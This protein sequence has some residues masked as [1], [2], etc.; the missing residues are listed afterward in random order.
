MSILKK[1]VATPLAGVLLFTAF[2]MNGSAV[3]APNSSKNQI[4]APGLVLE[5]EHRNG[6]KAYRGGRRGESRGHW[7]RMGPREIRRSLRHRG[8]HRIRIVDIHGPVYIIKARGW[9]DRRVRLVVDAHSGR[10]LK[11]RP[12]GQRRHWNQPW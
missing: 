2:A 3:A 11:R 6:R 9:Q 4:F 10:I 8:F 12:L 5:I 7:G 1:L